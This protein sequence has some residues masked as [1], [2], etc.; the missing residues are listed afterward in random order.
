[1]QNAYTTHSL[2]LSPSPAA[3]D[4]DWAKALR[5][6]RRFIPLAPCHIEELPSLGKVSESWRDLRK[7]YAGIPY[8]SLKFLAADLEAASGRG[9][10]DASAF[11]PGGLCY[12]MACAAIDLLSANGVLA[13]LCLAEWQG[14]PRGTVYGKHALAVVPVTD[15]GERCFVLLDDELMPHIPVVSEGRVARIE[16]PVGKATGGVTID[17]PSLWDARPLE[18][19]D[20]SP[21]YRMRMFDADGSI[22][23]TSLL[24]PEVE[25]LHPHHVWSHY[26]HRKG[27]YVLRYK[28]AGGLVEGYLSVDLAKER[29]VC[30]VRGEARG[31]MFER[32]SLGVSPNTAVADAVGSWCRRFGTPSDEM[33]RAVHTVWENRDTVRDLY[34]NGRTPGEGEPSYYGARY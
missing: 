19:E 15:K 3:P 27:D 13:H 34:W 6:P 20:L 22:V 31:P 7:L 16:A 21:R 26:R 10:A 30:S 33:F 11:G 32:L 8:N 12:D 17:R 5:A 1:M 18:G 28:D 29:L 9:T 23:R 25:L 4:D 2:S 24:N 14:G